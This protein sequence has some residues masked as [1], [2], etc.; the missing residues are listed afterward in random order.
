MASRKVTIE[1]FPS[2]IQKILQ[3]YGEDVDTNLSSIIDE[4]AQK[5]AQLLRNTSPVN[6]NGKKSGAYARNWSYMLDKGRITRGAVIYGKAP[7]YRL[8]HLLEHGH[9]LRQGG[10]S[11]AIP[12]I[13]PV[14]EIIFREIDMRLVKL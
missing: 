1:T 8:A 5:G 6:P 12:H 10:R 3:K 14:E 9:A 13:A 11:P 2:E 7:T 4:T